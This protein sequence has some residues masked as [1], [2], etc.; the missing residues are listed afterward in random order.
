[1]EK[2]LVLLLLIDLVILVLPMWS[3]ILLRTN[4]LAYLMEPNNIVSSM[5]GLEFPEVRGTMFAVV[6]GLVV[7]YLPFMVMPI[8]NALEKIEFEDNNADM[9]STISEHLTVFVF[10]S[11]V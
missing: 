4:A 9:I 7:T 6:F 10:S 3:N 5:L 8:Y 2:R 11:P 1:M